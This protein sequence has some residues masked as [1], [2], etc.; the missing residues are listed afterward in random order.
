MADS[1]LEQ[2]RQRLAEMASL[3]D[4]LKSLIEQLKKTGDLVACEEEKRLQSEI[5]SLQQRTASFSVLVSR[6]VE[7][8]CTPSALAD[9]H[10]VTE[11][12]RRIISGLQVK[13]KPTLH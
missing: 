3:I 11:G 4:S 13:L 2:A 9:I 6:G 5:S 7:T 12:L 1:A 8:V 10:S